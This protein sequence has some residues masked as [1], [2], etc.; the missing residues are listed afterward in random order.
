MNFD[1]HVKTI[2]YMT[3]DFS[4]LTNTCQAKY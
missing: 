1:G 3:M 2:F 4:H